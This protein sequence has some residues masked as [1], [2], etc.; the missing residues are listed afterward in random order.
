MVI[1]FMNIDIRG[2]IVNNFKNDSSK[3]MI[4]TINESLKSRNELILPG[5]GV[6][7]EVL[8]QESS[9]DEKLDFANKILKKIS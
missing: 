7:F 8:W 1:N 4:D 2:V 5:L 6:L 9:N 3:E